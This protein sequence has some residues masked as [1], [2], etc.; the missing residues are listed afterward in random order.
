MATAQKPTDVAEPAVTGQ[1]R[2]AIDEAAPKALAVVS[3]ASQAVASWNQAAFDAFCNTYMPKATP[4]EV[5]LFEE[6][7]R[8]TGL[9]PYARQV[10]PIK[11]SV[12]E[13]RDYVDRWSFQVSIDGFRLIAERTG[14]YRGQTT[15][16]FCGVDG[17]WKELWLSAEP[18]TAAKVGVLRSDFDAPLYAIAK[19]SEYA[20]RTRDG[21]LTSMWAKMA[22]LML[23]KVAEA[24]ALRKAFPQ[25]LS[26][27]YTTEEMGQADNGGA[28]NVGARAAATTHDGDSANG[29]QQQEK[30][31]P[32]DP[33]AV[34]DP[35]KLT[36]E[37]AQALPLFG[38]AGKWDGNA[39]KALRDVPSKVLVSVRTWIGDKLDVDDNRQPNDPQKLSDAKRHQW[40]VTEAAIALVLQG[41]ELPLTGDSAAREKA[42]APAE[43]TADARAAEKAEADKSMIDW[44]HELKALMDDELMPSQAREFF[45]WRIRNNKLNAPTS[46]KTAIAMAKLCLEIGEAAQGATEKQRKELDTLLKGTSSF[47]PAILT[48][49]RDNLVGAGA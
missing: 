20:Q 35:L 43:P 28:G 31:K 34:A 25:E 41:G 23:A 18:P 9:S 24:L 6:V 44:H 38:G 10:Y 37:Q 1:V 16:L 22:S 14:A 5:A 17:V 42:P 15:P 48:G 3:P 26:G 39:G 30:E 46:I 8:R 36:L 2:D 7:C 27:L 21:S 13:G 47:T 40:V 29:Q 11:R 12:R 45:S 33:F 32:A 19:W 4:A 49:I